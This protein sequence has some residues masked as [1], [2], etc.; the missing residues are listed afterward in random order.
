MMTSIT[1]T[2]PPPGQG[3]SIRDVVEHQHALVN[4]VFCRK[5]FRQLLASLELQYAQ[6]LPH[7]IITPDTVVIQDSGEPVLLPSDEDDL[8]QAGPADLHALAAVVHY[9]ITAEWPPGAPLRQRAQAGYSESLLGAIDKCLARD[10]RERPRTIDQ[11]RDLLGIVALVPAAPGAAP[12]VVEPAR[13]PVAASRTSWR[14][15]NLS[16]AQRWAL[17]GGAACLL[18]AALAGLVALLHDG[19]PGDDVALS[20]PAAVHEPRGLDPN[21]TVV[22]PP[23]KDVPPAIAAAPPG[24]GAATPPAARG[25]KAAPNQS[26]PSP[27]PATPARSGSP[28]PAQGL[29]AAPRPDTP[30]ANPAIART[31]YKVMIK[32]WGTVYVDGQD[33]GVSPPVK[34]LVLAAGKHTVRI[35]NPAYPD[36]VLRIEAGC[37]ADGKIAHDFSTASR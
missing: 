32:P 3:R 26:T 31:E 18:L 10:P 7:R 28:P 22:W 34:R 24:G 6:Q 2:A 29:A 19:D 15:P 23:S 25:T 5:I 9:A 14:N 27:V 12:A 36:R 35:V 17:V 20:L 33:R 1:S 21:E 37:S 11:L 4:E 30:H 13:K 16:R 8:G